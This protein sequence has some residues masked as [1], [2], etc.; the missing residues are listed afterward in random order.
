M[1]WDW[2]SAR[3]H[4]LLGM[5]ITV[6][7]IPVQPIIYVPIAAFWSGILHEWDDHAFRPSWLVKWV[8][9]P[10]IGDPAPGS[11]WQ[12]VLEAL[13]WLPAPILYWGI[14]HLW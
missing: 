3:Q 8:N 14:R 13:Q 4:A 9:D 1:H 10:T 7:M 11:P 6:I 2:K 12:G 5:I